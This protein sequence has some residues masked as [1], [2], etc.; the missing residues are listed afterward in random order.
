[1]SEENKTDLIEEVDFE[2]IAEKQADFI[3]TEIFESKDA[4]VNTAG[5]IRSFVNSYTENKD[6]MPLNQWLK[7]EFGKYPAVWKN[8]DDL[9]DTADEVIKSVTTLNKNKEELYAHL[10]AGK[11]RESFIARKIEEGA[12]AAGVVNVGE[13]A[14][15]IDKALQVSNDSMWST[16]T[17]NDGQINMVAHLDG[18]IA[19]QHHANSFN[20][21][22]VAKGSSL[23]AEV[24]TPNGSAYSANGVDIVIKDSSTGKT[25]RRYQAK[26][27]YD[28]DA[29]QKYFDKG[30]YRGQRKLVP[31]GQSG[32]IENSV[33]KIEADGISSK[34]LSKEA[35][36]ELQEKF[37]QEQLAREHKLYEWNDVNKINIAKNINK[38]AMMSAGVT[39]AFQG[40]RILGRRVWNFITGKENKS[41][42][43]DM[44]EFFE[45]S[46]KSGANV[47]VQVAVSGGV[48]VAARNGWIKVLKNTPAGKIA[49]M[50]YVGME[51]CKVI[52]KMFK[53]ELSVTEGLDAMGN[54]TCSAVGGIA[55]AGYGGTLGAAIGTAICPGLGTIVGGFVG[56]VA[57]GMAG[58]SIGKAIY[59]GGK[60]VAKRAVSVVRSVY[61]GAKSLVSS[62]C[63]SVGSFFSSIFG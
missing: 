13:Y 60:A 20:L 36:K 15:Q 22:A 44:Q 40:G 7:S 43:E 28:A 35:G 16:V 25:V 58:S 45:S 46:I 3:E 42:S 14:A 17:R 37:Q 1:M 52:Y 41:A 12:K 62:F 51:N 57:G 29:T 19:E 55:G 2:V 9:T 39:A 26:Y 54:V 6:K 31:E 59:E 38:Q 11:S 48:V 47:G 32:K 49:E 53:G 18:F 34:A 50:V 27:G 33:E 4:S 21:D 30:D 23:R 61:E 10:D 63:S 8:S 5:I 24:L 56:A